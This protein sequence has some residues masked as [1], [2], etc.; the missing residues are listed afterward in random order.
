MSEQRKYGRSELFL[1]RLSIPGQNSL[2]GDAGCHG[3]V[4]RVVDGEAYHFDDW[5]AL[6]A[7]LQAMLSSTT[8]VL[9]NAPAP[10]SPG[11]EQQCADEMT[12][13]QNS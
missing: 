1:V 12:A 5:Q 13:D 11:Q 10:C 4:Q 3:K 7:A 9:R 8:R 6:V 2:A